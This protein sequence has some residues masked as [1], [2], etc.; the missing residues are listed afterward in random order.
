MY[1][2][3]QITIWEKKKKNLYFRKI[4]ENVTTAYE[5]VMAT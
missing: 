5:V 4:L 2:L 1:E 3:N